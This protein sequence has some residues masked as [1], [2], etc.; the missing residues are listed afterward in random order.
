MQVHSVS[1]SSAERPVSHD[2]GWW[3]PLPWRRFLLP[4]S[5]LVGNLSQGYSPPS[6]YSPPRL[7]NAPPSVKVTLNT[8]AHTQLT[9]KCVP[10][11]LLRFS[12]PSFLFR[13]SRN[14]QLCICYFL[15]LRLLCAPLKI[16]WRS[17]F[18]LLVKKEDQAVCR[19]NSNCHLRIFMNLVNLN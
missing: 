5:G 2:T 1:P 17:I 13:P 7:G 19:A 18:L 6:L 4:A 8:P 15:T 3:F 12:F 9:D 11:T 10:H 14:S 16:W